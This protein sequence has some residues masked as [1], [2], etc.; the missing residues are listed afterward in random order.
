M[1][2]AEKITKLSTLKPKDLDAALTTGGY[3]MFERPLTCKFLGITT[4]GDFCYQ[5]TYV[6]STEGE[7]S[8]GKL[9]VKIDKADK[10]VA[11]Y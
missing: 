11:D 2:T 5:F 9:F 7:V 10:I 8:T 3:S 6:D 1:I 4:G